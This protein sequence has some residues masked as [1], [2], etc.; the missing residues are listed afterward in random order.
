[1]SPHQFSLSLPF[2]MFAL[3]KK[4]RQ[5]MLEKKNNNN[6]LFKIPKVLT[7]Q[8]TIDT[9]DRKYCIIYGTIKKVNKI[10]NHHILFDVSHDN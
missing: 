4:I 1:M 7:M 8:Y 9:L 10:A 2:S 5:V 3:K 6:K